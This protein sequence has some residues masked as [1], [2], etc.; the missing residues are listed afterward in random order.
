MECPK[1]RKTNTTL[2]RI[3]HIYPV[4]VLGMPAFWKWV[5]PAMARAIL[6]AMLAVCA[7]ALGLSLFWFVKGLAIFGTLSLAVFLFIA[8]IFIRCAGA[9]K[10]Y[11][12]KEFVRC[13][14]CGLEWAASGPAENP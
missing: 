3:E 9:M 13:D 8:S 2:M 11:Q 6:N 14:A 10:H 7:A 12:K 4:Q 1:C 5:S